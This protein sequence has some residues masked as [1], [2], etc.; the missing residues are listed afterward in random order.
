MLISKNDTSDTNNASI[1]SYVLCPICNRPLINEE[2]V[3]VLRQTLAAY[4]VGGSI[5]GGLLGIAILPVLGFT[6]A[7]VLS[8]SFAASWQSAL[9][10]V[11][12]GS[13]F[14]LL[15]SLGATGIGVLLFGGIG[16]VTGGGALGLIARYVSAFNWCECGLENVTETD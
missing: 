1:M 11:S 3:W 2:N 13:T 7:G 14:A 12:A 6:S 9:G 10:L 4:T 8:G 15:Q 16:T 5:L